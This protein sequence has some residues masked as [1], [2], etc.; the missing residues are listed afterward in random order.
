MKNQIKAMTHYTINLCNYSLVSSMTV[1]IKPM[2]ITML[3]L[4]VKRQ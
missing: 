4:K 2:K 1:L 3:P